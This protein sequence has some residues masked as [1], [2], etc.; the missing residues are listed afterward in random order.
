MRRMLAVAVLTAL[1]LSVACAGPM[2][3]E[4]WER[5]PGNQKV[6]LTVRDYRGSRVLG[7]Q[8][9]V[10]SCENMMLMTDDP[11]ADCAIVDAAKQYFDD[12]AALI[13]FAGNYSSSSQYFSPRRFSFTQ[14]SLQWDVGFGDSLEIHSPFSG[15][16]LRPAV[17]VTGMIAIP[18]RLDLTEP[19][20]LWYN[21]DYGVLD[22]RPEGN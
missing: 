14:G 3:D 22:P 7:I 15:G 8:A 17:I 11:G 5:L 16:Q 6:E 4:A 18:D 13:V 1:A 10:L 21:D 20:R 19:F 12:R 2:K 9:F